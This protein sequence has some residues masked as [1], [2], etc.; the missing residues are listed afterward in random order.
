MTLRLARFLLAGALALLAGCSGDEGEARGTQ[1][2]GEQLPVKEELDALRQRVAS[3]EERS[4]ELEE[5]NRSL[6]KMI[7]LA[8]RDLRSRLSEMVQ[9][10]DGPIARRLAQRAVKI[11]NPP[12]PYLGFSIEANTPETAKE[13]G[14]SVTSGILVTQVAA[15]A[16]A[17]V[18]GLRKG[19][20]VLSFNGQATETREQLATAFRKVKPGDECT[21]GIARGKERVEFEITVGAR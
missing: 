7:A 11:P 21:L 1:E 15:G 5:Q 19:D 12:R 13:Q 17:D 10:T 2:G 14:L 6:E 20:V 8:E 4:R 16:P 9:Q 3:L 18:G